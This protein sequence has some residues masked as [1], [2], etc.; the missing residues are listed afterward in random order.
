MLSCLC[1]DPKGVIPCRKLNKHKCECSNRSPLRWY[2][3]AV[4][5][6]LLPCLD[7]LRVRV[8]VRVRVRTRGSGMEAT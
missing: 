4:Q 6:E 3:A 7:R 2:A 1:A 5:T 8:R